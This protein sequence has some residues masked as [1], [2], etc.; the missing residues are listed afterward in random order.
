V[1]QRLFRRALPGC[2]EALFLRP[3]GKRNRQ[4]PEYVEEHARLALD[5]VAPREPGERK[6]R[7]LPAARLH[8]IRLG[9]AELGVARLE[10]RIVEQRDLRRRLGRERLREQL[11]HPRGDRVSLVRRADP[12]G[13][14]RAAL[15]RGLLDRAETAVLAER[16]AAGEKHQSR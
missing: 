2:L 13:A 11:L 16:G 7:P 1:A 4:Q 14:G 3:R 8:E 15:G 10:P 9:D 6:E 5:F 12:P